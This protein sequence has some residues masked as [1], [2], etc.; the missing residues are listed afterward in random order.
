MMMTA[1]PLGLGET[2]ELCRAFP[3]LRDRA[4]AA[5][6]CVRLHRLDGV[7]DEQGAPCA[8]APARGWL[9]GWTPPR[10]R[11]ADPAARDVARAGRSARPTPR[12]SRTARGW[13]PRRALRPA[14]AASTCRCPDLRPSSVTDPGTMPPPMTRSSSSWPAR[15]PYAALRKGRGQRLRRRGRR[16]CSAV[17]ARRGAAS[18]CREFHSP[19]S[20]HWPCH[21]GVSPLQALQTNTELARAIY[22]L[23]F[24]L[25]R[26]RGQGGSAD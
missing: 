25:V 13:W 10:H 3:Q 2:D 14:A 26:M 1:V 11:A 17:F 22:A 21:F 4:G 6:D 8:A 20:G 19:H 24:Q 5:V 16:R 18:C 9:P 23:G 7:D 15:E 12:R